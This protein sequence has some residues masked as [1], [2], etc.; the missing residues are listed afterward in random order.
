[1]KSPDEIRALT[2]TLVET[3]YKQVEDDV[4]GIHLCVL[5]PNGDYGFVSAGG[6]AKEAIAAGTLTAIAE[7]FSTGDLED[8][9][10][11][12]RVTRAKEMS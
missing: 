12:I 8:L 7:N 1:M 10:Q 2:V 6:L 5:L 11:A 3:L 4:E 9:L